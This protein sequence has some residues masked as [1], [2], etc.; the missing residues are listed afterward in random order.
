MY[1]LREALRL[2][3]RYIEI[4]NALV[5]GEVIGLQQNRNDYALRWQRLP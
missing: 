2:P 4:E 1:K 3:L 5:R